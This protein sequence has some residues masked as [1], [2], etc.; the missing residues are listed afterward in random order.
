MACNNCNSD[1]IQ[2]LKEGF[3]KGFFCNNC[4]IGG[5]EYSTNSCCDNP[6]IIDLRFEQK[7]K[8]IVQRTGC[9]NCKE[10]IGGNKPKSNNFLQ[11][12][13]YTQ[14][15]F[16]V[17]K[18]K[19]SHEILTL[20]NCIHELIENFKQQKNKQWWENY[21]NY[22]KSQKWKEKRLL[23]IKREN[24]ICQGCHKAPI[25]EIHHTDYRNVYDELLFQLIGLCKKCHEKIPNQFQ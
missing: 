1:N 13:L 10:L 16:I 2:I 11:L 6:Y 25:Q 8:S 22:L 19:R 23:V 3:A 20:R 24:N 18:N 21:N 12:P 7:N 9:K 17:N 14:E 5:I 4:G 15:S